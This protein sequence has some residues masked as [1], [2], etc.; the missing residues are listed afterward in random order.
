MNL[1]MRLNPDLSDPSCAEPTDK[2]VA[3]TLACVPDRG[4]ANGRRLPAAPPFR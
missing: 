3:V 2:P 1:P 4:T